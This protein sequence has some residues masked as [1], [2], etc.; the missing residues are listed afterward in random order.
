MQKDLL[1]AKEAKKVTLVGF[2]LNAGL[3]ALKIY[4]GIMGKSAAMIA[5]GI[6][7]L[8]DFLTDIVV[9]VG[10]K[11]TSKPEDE[12]H[13]YG[14]DKYETVAT[15]LISL[16]LALAGYGI[17][18]SGITA[19]IEEINGATLHTPSWLAFY[20]ALISIVVKEGL[21]RYTV[22]VGKRINSAAVIA[23]AWHHRSDAFSSIGVSLGI[24]GAILLGHQWA[25]LDPIASIV[26]SFFIFKVAY[27]IL[28][29][30]VNELL[31]TAL[32]A[33]EMASINQAIVETEG[34]IDHH[35]LR[36]RRIGTRV[37]IETHILVSADLN[38][39]C[40]HE[41]STQ[42][43][44]KLIELFGTKSIITIHVEPHEPGHEDPC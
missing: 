44:L 32:T 8:S 35:K 19:I 34:V 22:H 27:D 15:A 3:T 12:D 28:I 37:A 43:E 36:T 4:A 10:F 13:Q 5:D 2:W 11:L 26:V 40:A 39:G 30:A 31:E 29:P 20:A 41:I 38:V 9:L 6:H 42:L 23:N 33:E 18:K 21:Y 16:F 25:I 24:G 17:L 7:S 14:H 1:R